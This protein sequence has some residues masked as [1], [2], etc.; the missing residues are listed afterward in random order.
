MGLKSRS[1]LKMSEVVAYKDLLKVRLR[2]Y[3]IRNADGLPDA[4]LSTDLENEHELFDEADIEFRP[5]RSH[6][7]PP[8]L[9]SG[10]QLYSDIEQ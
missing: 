9:C 2:F 8:S 3:P 7:W 5:E 6:Q 4:V 1:Q 10:L